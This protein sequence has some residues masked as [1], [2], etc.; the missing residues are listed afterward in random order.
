MKTY[1]VLVVTNETFL[2]DPFPFVCEADD[3]EHAE[4]QAE[5][6]YPDGEIVWVYKGNNV[7]NAYYDYYNS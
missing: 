5:N 4:E 3:T 6:A 7:E 1:V 2:N